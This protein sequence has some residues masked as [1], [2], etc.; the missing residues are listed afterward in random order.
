MQTSLFLKIILYNFGPVSIRRRISRLTNLQSMYRKD[1]CQ[2]ENHL[3]FSR[4]NFYCKSAKKKQI[5]GK[6][7]L[8]T[9]Q[10]NILI[11]IPL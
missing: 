3:N 4:F 9:K 1:A 10:I 5:E 8:I 11:L 7:T 2:L 6:T